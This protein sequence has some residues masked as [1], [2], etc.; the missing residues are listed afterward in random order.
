MTLHATREGQN[1]T[2][3]ANTG[4]DVEVRNSHV[5]TVKVTEVAQHVEHFHA[6]LGR[7]LEEAKAERAEAVDTSN[8]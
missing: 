8:T 4:V 5:V 6:Q 2:V 3:H 7:L 1:V